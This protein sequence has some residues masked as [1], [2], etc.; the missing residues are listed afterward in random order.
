MKITCDIC[1][2]KFDT[3]D[4]A[5][6]HLADYHTYIFYKKLCEAMKI[7]AKTLIKIE[8]EL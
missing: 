7:I 3:F 6:D 2:E 4:K 5:I 1:G 8:S